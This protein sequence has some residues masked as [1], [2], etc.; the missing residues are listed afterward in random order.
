MGRKRNHY[1]AKATKKERVTELLDP[2]HKPTP[3][4][5]QHHILQLSDKQIKNWRRILYAQ[6]GPFADLLPDEIVCLHAQ[7]IQDI[8]DGL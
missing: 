3:E 2:K 1:N 6:L 8:V 7:K 4:P 5:Q